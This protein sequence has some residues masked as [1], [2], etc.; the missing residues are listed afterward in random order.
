[1]I[2]KLFHISTFLLISLLLPIQAYAYT[3]TMNNGSWS[4]S[5]SV[6]SN[7][8]NNTNGYISSN[9][10]VVYLI[11]NRHYSNMVSFS[12]NAENNAYCSFYGNINLYIGA[13]GS[14]LNNIEWSTDGDDVF[15]CK[16]EN[17]TISAGKNG[18]E[19]ISANTNAT[20]PGY[21]N[22]HVGINND[23]Q[24][25]DTLGYTIGD[26][27]PTPTP[28]VEPTPTIELTPTPAPVILP[29][30]S[31]EKTYLHETCL[32]AKFETVPDL[33]YPTCT[34]EHPRCYKD[35]QGNENEIGLPVMRNSDLGVMPL[36]VY[37]KTNSFNIPTNS[38]VLG[39][40]VSF[41]GIGNKF[42]YSLKDDHWS[43][44]YHNNLGDV[45]NSIPNP[46]ITTTLYGESYHTLASFRDFDNIISPSD[47]DTYF[48]QDNYKT[49]LA[50]KNYDENNG[51]NLKNAIR[52]VWYRDNN[53]FG[54]VEC[55]ETNLHLCTQYKD[56][57]PPVNSETLCEPTDIGCHLNNFKNWFIK[58]F[59]PDSEN[60][61]EIIGLLF[62]D[63]E[64]S[65]DSN[66]TSIISAPLAVIGNLTTATCSPLNLPL[67]FVNKNLQLPCFRPLLVNQFP[68]F[69]VL[70]DLVTTG[71]ISYYVV[72]GIFKILK[73]TKDPD[74]DKI[75]V[76]D[77]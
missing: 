54:A 44:F 32:L 49:L 3:W 58:L 11:P 9:E 6:L 40:S 65:I 50:V 10:T 34:N 43:P 8:T 26:A 47:I 39:Q 15:Y 75:E 69:F 56:I 2:K 5:G 63:F 41:L 74:N 17:G 46:Y 30:G 73:N 33:E 59:I 70:F 20:H 45:L 13:G 55:N 22:I 12:Q 35:Y 53:P 28:T 52:C 48:N 14:W 38:K 31:E 19:L 25:G 67:P 18:V 7:F 72:L 24:S 66:V 29:T 4:D 36:F 76:M 37:L 61:G 23:T 71:V 51:V 21:I 60:L 77:I 64:E 42:A 1:M 27:V 57:V 16:L 68:E 62:T